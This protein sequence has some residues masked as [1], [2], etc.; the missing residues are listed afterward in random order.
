[1]TGH[2][3][4]V[5]E[6]NQLHSRSSDGDIHATQVTQETDLSV[7]V[8]SHQRDDDDVALLALEAIDGINADSTAEGLVE[9]ALHQKTAQI[10]HLSAIRRDDAYINTLVQKPLLANLVEVILQG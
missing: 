8:A 5:A 9:L 10:L 3:I 6:D 2:G 4:L 1:M 7:I